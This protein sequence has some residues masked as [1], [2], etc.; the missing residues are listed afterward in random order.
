MG[1]QLRDLTNQRFGKLTVISFAGRVGKKHKSSV[2]L[3]RCDC[4][5]VRIVHMSNLADNR[6]QGCGVACCLRPRKPAI[7]KEKRV[8]P[9]HV[10]HG[11]TYTPF[12]AVWKM[13]NQRCLNKKNASYKNYGGRAI[14]VEWK[15]FEDFKH[16]MYESYLKHKQTHTTTTI[17]RKDNNGNYS[18]HNCRW[19]TIQEQARNKRKTY[20]KRCL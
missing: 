15:C 11:M 19:A 9:Y 8:P 18:S 1:R 10:T 7:K 5:R 4:G 6:T 12:Y 16:D 14:T 20:T 13:M 17:E 2:W 3:C